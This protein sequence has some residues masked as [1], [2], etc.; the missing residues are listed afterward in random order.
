MGLP[1][2]SPL[3]IGLVPWSLAFVRNLGS[4]AR[5][6]TQ[7]G[8]RSVGLGVSGLGKQVGGAKSERWHHPWP[9]LLV[10]WGQ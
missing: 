6:L 4:W 3:P 2:V 8:C 7:R 9:L 1:C 5:A 10:P